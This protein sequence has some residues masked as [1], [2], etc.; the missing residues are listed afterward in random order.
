MNHK[1]IKRMNNIEYLKSRKRNRLKFY[2]YND[3]GYYYIT[4]CCKIHINYFGKTKNNAVVLSKIGNIVRECWLTIPTI[5]ADIDLDCFIIM[6]N[7]MHG[8]LCI[9]DDNKKSNNIRSAEMLPKIIQNLKSTSTKQARKITSDFA[10]Q[11]SYYDHVIRNEKS[12]RLIREYIVNNPI[13][14]E[15]DY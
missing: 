2:N 14:C 3:P 7:H 5:Y 15:M 8:I 4:I 12:L 13:K 11:R 9:D 6:P 1:M 10:W